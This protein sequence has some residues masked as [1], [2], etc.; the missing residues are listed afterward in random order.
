MHCCSVSTE[1][2]N[3]HGGGQLASTSVGGDGEWLH[4]D[5]ADTLA[6]DDGELDV[7]LVTPGGVPG[8]L[9]RPVVGTVLSAPT[10]DEHGVVQASATGGAV[11]DTRRVVLEDALVSLDGDSEGLA[12]EG[13]LH[14]GDVVGCD[15]VVV[16]DLDGGGRGLIV[17]TSASTSGLARDV[18]V[19]GLK[20]GL[21]ALPV[22]E[23]LVL[24]STV[25]AV[26]ASRAV[27]ELLLGE[28]EERSSPDLVDTFKDTSR[29]ERP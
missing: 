25:A 12:G 24:P 27:N 14:L 8:V 22:L 5:T 17:L 26:V 16:G 18:G 19:G 21:V 28:G 13:R 1:T 2:M 4:L 29:G 6:V 23:G 3:E 20:L 10:S 11:K 7:A 15:E 9:H